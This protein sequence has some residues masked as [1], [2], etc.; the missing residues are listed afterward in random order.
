M[1]GVVSFESRPLYSR[2]NSPHSPGTYSMGGRVDPRAGLDVASLSLMGL[3]PR[4]LIL[5]IFCISSILRHVTPISSSLH[6]ISLTET[7]IT[8]SFR[9]CVM[10]VKCTHIQTNC[11]Q[12]QALLFPLND[13]NSI[14]FN[15]IH[16][17]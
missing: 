5:C 4:F 7:Q 16:V 2:E 1:I 13:N 6:I 14:Q 10:F 9:P 11:K 3:E 8:E 17:Y 12:F 15:S